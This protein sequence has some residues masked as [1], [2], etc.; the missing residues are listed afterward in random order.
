MNEPKIVY[1]YNW[2]DLIYIIKKSNGEWCYR[3]KPKKV[4]EH[5][6]NIFPEKEEY[7][8]ETI[9]WITVGVT[10]GAKIKDLLIYCKESE[11]K[12]L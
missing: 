2:K 3:F 10:T 12:T 11:N 8:K 9:N 5:L 7:Q 1:M 4:A 6:N